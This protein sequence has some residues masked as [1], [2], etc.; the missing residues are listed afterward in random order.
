MERNDY[1]VER[2]VEGYELNRENVQNLKLR[3][4]KGSSAATQD[5]LRDKVP[6]TLWPQMS[7][8]QYNAK[9]IT[10][11]IKRGEISDGSNSPFDDRKLRYDRSVIIFDSEVVGKELVTS[12]GITDYQDFLADQRASE[13]TNLEIQKDGEREFGDRYVFFSRCPGIAVLPLTKE[14]SAFVGERTNEEA[15]GYLN[16]V[17]GHLQ[18]R[19]PE[20]VD[21]QK[22]LLRELSEEFGIQK[23]SLLAE[24]TFVGIYSHPIKGDLDFTF[25][26]QTD[27]PDEYFVSGK[28]KDNVSEGEHKPL[29]QLSSMADIQKLLDDGKVPDGRK[30]PLMYSTRG[31]L[32]SLTEEDLQL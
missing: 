6:F 2:S 11:K 28:W 31:A 21:L 19:N 26:V 4:V 14:K 24:P 23:E 29:I 10:V 12:L 20:K 15:E 8:D 9:V 25:I 30:L 16:A 3:F 32:E 17:A 27:I 7:F 22:D 5:R 18:F 1:Q 13:E